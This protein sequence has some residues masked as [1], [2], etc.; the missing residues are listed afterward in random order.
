[1]AQYPNAQPGYI[2]IVDIDGQ[3]VRC[4]NANMQISQAAEFY[5]HIVGLRDSITG[6]ALST[7]GDVGNINYQKYIWR[8]GVRIVNGDT[9]FPV[10]ESMFQKVW[11]LTRTGDLFDTV[12]DLTCGIRRT[13]NN[14]RVSSFN[15][16]ATAGDVAQASVSFVAPDV[17]EQVA[18]SS[19]QQVASYSAPDFT[20]AQKL[21]TWD[22]VEVT[23]DVATDAVSSFDFTVSNDTIPIYTS[24]QLIPK[25][26]RVGMQEVTG[27]MSFY[28]R[29]RELEFLSDL[30]VP[31][32]IRLKVGNVN[33]QLNVI[34]EPLQREGA[35]GPLTFG[36]GFVGVGKAMN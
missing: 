16:T 33:V 6:Y 21:I 2:G 19:M 25:K 35:T 24:G 13:A 36:L 1:M 9:A 20:T 17:I 4:T 5:D 29:D 18:G 28:N 14:C 15:F 3:K 27:T 26:I 11:G 30:S 22:A 23:T 7:K 31:H 32:P 34:F 8:P 12:Q 10:T